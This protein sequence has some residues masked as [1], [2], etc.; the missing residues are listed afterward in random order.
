MHLIRQD[1]AVA[2]LGDELAQVRGREAEGGVAGELGLADRLRLSP[3][4]RPVHVTCSETAGFQVRRD[5]QHT[6]VAAA[7][8]LPA[9]RAQR[10]HLGDDVPAQGGVAAADHVDGRVEPA[11]QLE[12]HA[13]DPGVQRNGVGLTHAS[14]VGEDEAGRAGPVEAGSDLVGVED[15]HDG[16][17]VH[18]LGPGG[19]V[20]EHGDPAARIGQRSPDAPPRVRLDPHR[21]EGGQVHGRVRHGHSHPV[22]GRVKRSGGRR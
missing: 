3:D 8:H 22:V 10:G 17:V 21:R 2:L 15:G 4:P 16:D 20:V 18:R 6:V 1:G 13:T 5:Q 14:G 11:A 12:Q 7:E 9:H 19:V